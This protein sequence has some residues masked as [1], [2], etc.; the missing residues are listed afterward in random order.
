M[1]A[2]K[3]LSVDDSK[4]IH[5][6]I[7]RAFKNYDVE[8]FFAGNGVEGLAMC[9][10]ENP[11]IVLLDVTM[12]VMDGVET[13]SKIK[14]DPVIK[15]IPVIML[16]AEA[17]RENVVKIAKLGVRD[18]IIKP[19]TEQ[20]IV[21]RVGR[22]IDLQQKGATNAKIKTMDDPASI[23]VVD[24]KP[25]IIEQIRTAVTGTPWK[26]VGTAQCGEAID[27]ASKE[28]P[29]VILVS[30]SLQ[31][32]AAYNFFQMMRANARTKSVPILGMS[33]KTA[34]EEQAQAQAMGFTGIITKPLEPTDLAFRLSRAMN[35]DTSKRYFVQEDGIQFVRV[36]NSPT[37]L[38]AAE[39][40]NYIQ[41]KTKE[42]VESGL[43][44]L[45]LDVSDVTKID[46]IVI[47]LMLQVVQ[48]CKELGIKLR[49]VGSNDFAAQ[50][51]G[52]EETKDI[53]LY[54]DRPTALAGF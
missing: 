26:V 16:T 4:M 8:L 10:R 53:E 37:T 47:K 45:I 25:T 39:I 31:D 36:P 1:I 23:L 42:M 22:V 7:G 49:V 40:S 2:P 32:R 30:L 6:V 51:K 17:G 54:S 15:D 50:S 41:P 33:V 43:N 21:E 3:I 28:V 34:T 18:Y 20:M 14:A 24:D 12:P 27:L 35:L 5:M 38:V 11:D 9:T 52:F 48:S 46:M 19:F 29:D 44:R 13:L